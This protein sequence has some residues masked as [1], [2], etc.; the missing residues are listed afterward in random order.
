MNI[1]MT[2]D[3]T[4]KHTHRAGITDS[5]VTKCKKEGKVPIHDTKAHRVSGGTALPILTTGTKWEWSTSRAGHFT[6]GTF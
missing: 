6:P 3:T 4:N 1:F 2:T 5:H